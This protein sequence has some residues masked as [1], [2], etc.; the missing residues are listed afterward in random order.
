MKH[1]KRNKCMLCFSAE[2]LSLAKRNFT[3]NKRVQDD[4]V[5]IDDFI[6]ADDAELTTLESDYHE[7]PLELEVTAL[8]QDAHAEF[9]IL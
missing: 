8:H 1:S 2:S 9:H 7:P 4:T 5:V 6:A 3:K